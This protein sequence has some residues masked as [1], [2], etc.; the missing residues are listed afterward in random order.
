MQGRDKNK[1][2]CFFNIFIESSSDNNKFRQILFDKMLE[3]VQCFNCNGLYM[4]I[5]DHPNYNNSN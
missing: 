3:E 1:Q 5:F 2:K 4:D